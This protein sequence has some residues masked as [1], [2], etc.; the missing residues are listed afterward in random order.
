MMFHL[1]CV[2]III[3]RFHFSFWGMAQLTCFTICSLNILLIKI[4]V[5]PVLVFGLDLFSD[6]FN[7]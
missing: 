4:L 3:F 7:S 5:I 2:R 6:W 1:T